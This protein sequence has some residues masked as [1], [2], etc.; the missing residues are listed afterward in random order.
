ME[1]P[2]VNVLQ[3]RFGAAGRL[4]FRVGEGGLP[5]AVLASP[6]GS[7]E[8]S[9]YGGQV[10]RYKPLGHAPVLFVSRQAV[11]ERGR[12]IRGGIPVCWP[13]FGAHPEDPQRPSHGFARLIPWALRAA[14]YGAQE[15]EITLAVEDDEQTRGWW[16]NPFALSL[17]V[18]LG[19]YL[20]LELTT[21]NTGGAP[22][23][24]TEA[25]H[26][27]LQVRD[28]AQVRVAGLEEAPYYD[29]CDGRS[30]PAAPLPVTFTGEVDRVYADAAPSCR[31]EDAGLG[32][33]IVVSKRNSRAT[34]VWNP[35]EEKARRMPDLGEGAF[36]QMLCVETANARDAAL[37]LRPGEEHT[38]AMGLQVELQAP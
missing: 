11:Y 10:L 36:R 16:P 21:R 13:W 26:T 31:V 4:A 35:G 34:V 9:L 38:L 24:I 22:F 14:E 28:V 6:H 33:R 18:V 3:K 29:L 20:R 23:T 19:P 7:C 12:A 15:T 30:H 37:A 2:D 1:W 17:R 8:V 25:L 32:R 5:V 27:Y